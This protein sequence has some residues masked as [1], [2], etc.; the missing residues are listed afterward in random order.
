MF[1]YLSRGIKS[2][3]YIESILAGSPIIKQNNID[4]KIYVGWGLKPSGRKAYAAAKRV[5][6]KAIYLEDG[7]V[8]SYGTG[9]K[10]PPL[11]IIID[12]IGIYY[13]ATRSS[14]LELMLQSDKDL[15]SEIKPQ[16]DPAWGYIVNKNISKYNHAADLVSNF[17]QGD[18]EKVLVVD[19]T[20]GDLSIQ[21]GMANQYSFNMMLEAAID[22]NPR[23]TIYLKTHPEV[24]SGRKK[25]YLSSVKQND[26]V[27]LITQLV[28]PISLLKL[29]DKTYVVTSQM[30]FESLLVGK[31]VTCF[32]MPYYAGW[33][34]TDDRKCCTRRTKNRSVSEIF[35][36]AYFHYTSYL[37][38]YTH[39]AGSIF[40][41]LEY[42]LEQKHRFQKA[43]NRIYCIDFKKWRQYNFKPALSLSREA[44]T[45]K[46]SL[47]EINRLGPNDD[48]IVWGKSEDNKLVNTVN[49]S[50]ARMLQMEDGFVRSVGLGSD[51]IRPKSFV[52]DQKGIYFDSTMH[53]DL[54]VL[55]NTKQF[56]ADELQRAV[57]I[58]EFIVRHRITKYNIEP[59]DN[60]PINPDNRKVI[61]VPGQVDSDASIQYGAPKNQNN[62]QLLSIVRI[63]HPHAY[64]I[65][66]PHPD[67]VSG[68]RKGRFA[69]RNAAQYVDHVETNV[70][71]LSCIEAAD[72]V[73]TLTSLCGFDALLREKKVYTY[74]LPFYAGWGLT[75][76]TLAC[77]R[78]QRILNLD[79]LVAGCLID[80]P[81]YWDW[82]LYGY[83]KCETVLRQIVEERNQLSADGRLERLR[84][85]FVRRQ[86]RKLGVLAKA[87]VS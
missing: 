72:E 58:R 62:E 16:I 75:S 86:F 26:R 28:N 43:G 70:S 71:A 52:L 24:T 48:V 1:K 56:T 68:N 69:L 23:A 40:N 47:T 85:G 8:R 49:K 53:S 9:D 10:Y 7:F 5:G 42:L 6:Q 32:G 66:K 81:I 2:I 80:Y 13:D 17:L 39:Q 37:N 64:I 73:H 34:V 22:E 65:Y 46:K 83:T 20:F 15:L 61:F 67:V 38:P 30:G 50:G 44:V 11:S 55:L 63:N 25:G 57:N 78:R 60:L 45:F 18:G 19:Q 51:L 31:P 35:A 33:G 79:E 74:G 21:Y 29:I 27:K 77:E 3:P 54:E 59:D 87:A 12:D 14:R 76:D 4:K 82:T 84:K 36:A 41:V